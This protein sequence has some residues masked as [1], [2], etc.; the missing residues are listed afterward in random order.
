MDIFTQIAQSIITEQE[1][2]IGP[3]ALEQAQKVTGVKVDSK[4]H[5]VEL[6]GDKT[7]VIEQLIEKYRDLFGQASVEVCRE[8][9]KSLLPK[10]PKE[11]IPQL[12]Q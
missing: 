4:T 12:L 11:Q 6:E 2:I 10:V 1:N 5:A 8:A 7:A 9:V 3:I